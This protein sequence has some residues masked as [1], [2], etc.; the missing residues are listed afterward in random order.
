MPPQTAARS[1]VCAAC[2]RCVR[3]CPMSAPATPCIPSLQ[4]T[5]CWWRPPGTWRQGNK[6]Q[7]QNS[8]RRCIKGERPLHDT[9]LW[10]WIF[11]FFDFSGPYEYFLNKQYMTIYTTVIQYYLYSFIVTWLAIKYMYKYILV[12]PRWR[13]SCCLSKNK[14]NPSGVILK[15]YLFKAQSNP[16]YYIF[17]EY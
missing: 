6:L 7:V 12:V 8:A 2:T 17:N 5:A 15:S 10:S 14:K 11:S 4:T 1:I 16:V 9:E 13:Y 3:W